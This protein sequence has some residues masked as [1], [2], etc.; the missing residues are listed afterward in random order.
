MARTTKQPT[1]LDL[2]ISAYEAAR[3]DWRSNPATTEE[4]Q[5][6]RA[7]ERAAAWLLLGR[8]ARRGETMPRS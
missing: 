2:M 1:T 8:A 5:N 6:L 7:A 4:E 3:D